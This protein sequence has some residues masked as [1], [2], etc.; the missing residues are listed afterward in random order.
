MSS[1]SSKIV[2]E[3][4]R[5]GLP[6]P[7]CEKTVSFTLGFKAALEEKQFSDPDQP[8]YVSFFFFISSHIFFI[9]ISSSTHSLNS[10]VTTQATRKQSQERNL[11]QIRQSVR[12]FVSSKNVIA[13]TSSSLARFTTLFTHTPHTDTIQHG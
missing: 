12:S 11:R 6:Q 2:K 9:H 13:P 3:A 10:I 1:L 8:K 4:V 7:I 5:A